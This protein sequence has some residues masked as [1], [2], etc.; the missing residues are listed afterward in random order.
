M[1][2]VGF[3]DVSGRLLATFGAP[4]AQ[5]TADA[6][7]FSK[8]VYKGVFQ[9]AFYARSSVV[10]AFGE[11]SSGDGVGRTFP[12][13]V[14]VAFQTTFYPPSAIFVPVAFLLPFLLPS[15]A[16]L[17]L[18]YAEKRQLL[19]LLSFFQASSKLLP[20]AVPDTGF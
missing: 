8:T 13:R 6:R 15:S 2:P 9:R 1:H 4:S 10:R 3:L 19:F 5:F 11:R 17:C 18:L 16:V 7:V 12:W 14:P 20:K